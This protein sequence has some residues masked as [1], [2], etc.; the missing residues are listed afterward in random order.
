LQIHGTVD[1]TVLYEGGDE[2]LGRPRP[3]PGAVETTEIWATYNNCS[4]PP[5]LSQPPIDLESSITGRE[6]TVATFR[7]GCDDGGSAELWT[8]LGGSHIPN[9]SP[10]FVP[11]VLDF[12]LSDGQGGVVVF[13][14]FVVPAAAYAAGA[15]G[16]FYETDLDLS[17]AGVNDAEV[18]FL[19]LPRGES[20]GDP[21]TSEPVMVGA[22]QSVRYSNVLAE[23]FDL[24]P[25]AFGALR[26]D[27]TSDD[28]RAVARIANTPQEPD[29]GSFGQ[30]MTAIRPGDCTGRNERRRLLFGT[31]NDD[32]RFNVGCVNASDMATRVSFELYGS[33]GTMLG[34]ESM[35]LLPWS[36]NQLDRIFDV[37]KPVTGHVEYLADMGGGKVYCYGSL[38]DN[39]TSDPTTIPPM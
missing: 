14:R 15:E 18:R 31:E 5:D 36:N 10:E 30:A 16:S 22:G 17:N 33:D 11:R 19:W 8:I 27:A 39:V 21:M 1:D 26:I 6:T 2:V 38:L 28:L 23:V 20:N 9:L 37:Y 4:L 29:A 32:M 24:E 25:D 13:P 35:I 34:A 12:F 3:Y 7:E